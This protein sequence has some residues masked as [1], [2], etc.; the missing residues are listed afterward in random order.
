MKVLTT[1][2]F[3]LVASSSAFAGLI[4]VDY[5]ATNSGYSSLSGSFS[6]TDA[7]NDGWLTFNELDNWNTNYG[8]GAGFAD[9]NDLGDFDYTNNIW[10]PN[11]FQWNQVTEDAYMTWNNWGY[12]ASTSNYNW[13]FDTAVENIAAVPEPGSLALLGLGI[14]GLG[15]AR[16]S[17]KA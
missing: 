14:V 3:S 6:G 15:L 5:Q 12:S 7:N 8:S 1:L 10:T 2:A 13:V 9:L 17:K 11:A 4:T 16:R